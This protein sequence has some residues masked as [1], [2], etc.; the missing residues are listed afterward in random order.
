MAGR[1]QSGSAGADDGA[2]GDGEGAAG[3]G[4][5]DRFQ[6]KLEGWASK[7]ESAADFVQLPAREGFE[8]KDHLVDG[9]ARTGRTLA[10]AWGTLAPKYLPFADAASDGLPLNRLLRLSLFQISVGMAMVLLTG[11]LNRVMNVEMNIP[12]FAIAIMVALPILFAPFR[13]LIGFKSDHFR[14]FIGWRRVPF[15]WLGTL[16]QFLGLAL[17][18]FALMLLTGEGNSSYGL[19]GGY[20]GGA[21]AFLMV[22]LGFHT[23][24]TAGLALATDLA[25]E[26]RRPRVV[27]LM[28]VMLLVGMI[29][30][31]FFFSYMLSPFSETALIRTIQS[32][33]VLTLIL[34][35]VALWKQEPRDP[36]RIRPDDEAPEPDFREAWARFSEQPYLKT[37]LLSIFLGTAAFSMQDILLE[38]FGG[39]VLDLKVSATTLLTAFFA[40]GSLLG[41]GLSAKVLESG[42][43]PLQLS[44]IGL[45]VGIPAFVCVILSGLLSSAMLYYLGSILVGLGGG[46]FAVGTL[47]AAMSLAED[48][49][50]GLTLGAWGAVQATAMGGATLLGGV[51]QWVFEGILSL[52]LSPKAAAYGG[53]LCV[54]FVE[55]VLLIATVVVILPLA[56]QGSGGTGLP[57]GRFG[58]SGLPG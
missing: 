39:K 6:K 5:L 9:A 46:L 42:F 48:W 50:A 12:I 29:L 37:L 15:I 45:V 57:R 13:I 16:S 19:L 7:A 32:V 18:P 58:L 47:T 20:L 26:S 21:A 22:G 23:T 8:Q 43:G 14:S 30:A 24:Q 33:G 38:P 27:A 54:Y 31:S 41:F 28:Y 1:V 35:L 49:D 11:T 4:V 10:S 51:F 52:M 25:D 36:G 3:G 17:M 2:P 44:T 40:F 53:F 55:I 56:R 34:N